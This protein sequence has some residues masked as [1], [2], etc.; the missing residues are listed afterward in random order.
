MTPGRRPAAVSTDDTARAFLPFRTARTVAPVGTV[1]T[2]WQLSSAD[3]SSWVRVDEHGRASAS[4]D[5]QDV[6]YRTEPVAVAPMSGVSYTPRFPGDP[7][8]IF[9]HARLI[10][11]DNTS[12]LTGTPPTLPAVPAPAADVVY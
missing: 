5:L 6:L 3:G 2:M 8:G 9:L 4:P 10:L 1:D 7:T 12:R 11:G